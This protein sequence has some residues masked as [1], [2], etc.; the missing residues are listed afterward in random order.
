MANKNL[1]VI[2]KDTSVA[3]T[4]ARADRLTYFSEMALSK[5]IFDDVDKF[6]AEQ[7]KEIALKSSQEVVESKSKDLVADNSKVWLDEDTGLMWQNEEY[8]EKEEEA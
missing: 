1:P 3:K 6:L 2:V 5:D 4:L 8:T 7:D